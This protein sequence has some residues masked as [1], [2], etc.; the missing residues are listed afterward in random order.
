INSQ[1][2]IASAMKVKFISY[3]AYLN[4]S[5]TI[6]DLLDPCNKLSTF[7]VYECKQAINK[8]YELH[9]KF[10]PTEE[11][12]LFLPSTTTKSTYTLFRKLNQSRQ[13][14]LNQY[15]IN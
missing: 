11:N 7:D 13:A 6:S 15:K 2:A 4:E 10:R 5:S 9:I 14:D 12:Q 8:L 3:W 1:H